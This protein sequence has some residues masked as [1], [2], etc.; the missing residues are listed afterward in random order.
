[1]EIIL[2]YYHN[3]NE[4]EKKWASNRLMPEICGYIK[5]QLTKYHITDPL[6]YEDMLHDG[7]QYV[8][9]KI[10][11]EYKSKG[12]DKGIKLTTFSKKNIYHAYSRA[13]GTYIYRVKEHYAYE[14]AQVKKALNKLE[15]VYNIPEPTKAEIAAE[16]G[17]DWT[18]QKVEI[19]LEIIENVNMASLDEAM[20]VP[21]TYDNPQKVIEKKALMQDLHN[22]IDKLD[23]EQKEVFQLFYGLHPDYQDEYFSVTQIGKLKD[24]T[25]NKAR[26]LLEKAK[27]K[28]ARDKKLSSYFVDDRYIVRREPDKITKNK[29]ITQFFE[30]LNNDDEV[31]E[32]RKPVSSDEEVSIQKSSIL[33][34]EKISP[35]AEKK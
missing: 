31:L 11:K 27:K 30:N 17:V 26:T 28:V 21:D 22:A 3:G 15:N 16:C 34:E 14:I 6:L 19:I 8:L 29:A 33:F 13:F 4:K 32:G 18:P 5:S 1:M 35:N 23:L 10:L 7:Y 20:E 24:I 25:F 9:P 12:I 2:Y